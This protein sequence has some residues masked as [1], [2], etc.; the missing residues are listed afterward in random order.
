MLK[1]IVESLKDRTALPVEV[2]EI[3]AAII[4][5]GCQ[6]TIYFKGIDEEDPAQI[7]GAFWQYVRRPGVYADPEFVALIPYNNR[8]T[9]AWQR[10][11]CCKEMVHLF[12]S[13][14]ERTDKS[15]EVVDLIGRL[16][17]RLSTD[18]FGVVDL[19]ASKDKLALYYC[20]PLLLPKAA[21]LV[22]R[23]AVKA[24]TLTVKKVAEDACMPI[25]LVRLMLNEEWDT[26]NGHLTGSTGT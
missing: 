9:V 7:H 2:E 13:D 16:L 5:E 21:L 10:V 26:L 20:L 25:G 8:D 3:S 1:K 4:R 14:L 11:T 17:S 12:D 15:D 18:D 24:G 19:M 23:D 6:D 22:A